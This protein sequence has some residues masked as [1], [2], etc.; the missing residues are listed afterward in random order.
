MNTIIAALLSNQRLAGQAH[1]W[2][3]IWEH[4]G[5]I[6]IIAFSLIG[7]VAALSVSALYPPP[8]GTYTELMAPA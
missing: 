6:V 5:L 4:H 7:L 8:E 2:R 1:S 3:R